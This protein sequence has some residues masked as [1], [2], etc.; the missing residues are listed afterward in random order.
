MAGGGRRVRAS[1]DHERL[2]TEGTAEWV[3][4]INRADAVVLIGGL[5]GT[6]TASQ[7][8]AEQRKPV[9]PL[10]DTGR[11]A[12]AFYIEMLKNWDRLGPPAVPKPNFQRMARPAP[13]VVADLAELLRTL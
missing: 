2:L 8:A 1:C 10:A 5:G 12:K 11:D 7:M 3:E 4:G 9:F 13:D 6:L